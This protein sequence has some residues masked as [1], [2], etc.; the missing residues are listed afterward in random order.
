M[1][2]YLVIL[3]VNALARC[4]ITSG[5]TVPLEAFMTELFNPFLGRTL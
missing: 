5:K 3:Q 1:L 2:V 4:L